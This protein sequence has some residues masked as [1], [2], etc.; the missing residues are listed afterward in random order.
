MLLF[1]SVRSWMTVTSGSETFGLA[2]AAVLLAA[3]LAALMPGAA[4][5]QDAPAPTLPPC[6]VDQPAAGDEPTPDPRSVAAACA[7]I[8]AA[9]GRAAGQP[10]APP[11]TTTTVSEEDPEGARSELAPALPPADLPTSN[12]EGYVFTLE[13]SLSADLASAA[14]EAPVY[15]VVVPEPTADEAR[16]LADR[17]GLTG[18]VEDR[19]GATFVVSGGG[20]LYVTPTLT[21]YIAAVPAAEGELPDDDAAIEQASAWL[22]DVGLAPADIGDGTVVQRSAET[23]RAV[24]AFAP[25]SPTPILAGY[26]SITVSVDPA[27]TVL[28]AS[29]R[30]ATIQQADVYQLR[31]AEEAWSQVGNGQAYIEADLAEA[32]LEPGA[33][34]VGSVVYE[35]IGLAYTTA[36]PP[37][38]E[39]YLSPVYV[40]SGDLTLSDGGTYPVSSY[41]PALI[42][43]N[44]PVGV[45]PAPGR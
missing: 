28:D 13:A 11:A 40:F 25:V 6:V 35:T 29:Y 37:G 23:R 20:E 30:W 17:L 44:T 4:A 22:R 8:A 39:Q 33:E 15:R 19:G 36:G 41:V 26:P 32:D 31:P 14:V 34:V 24:V 10:T 16:A 7:T 27:G 12:V 5:A 43:S 38:G 3:L 45:V 9:I 21:Q 1:R 2:P 18:D 42:D